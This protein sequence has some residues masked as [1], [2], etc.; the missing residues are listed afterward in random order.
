MLC[1]MCTV[2][3]RPLG[4]MIAGSEARSGES[5]LDWFGRYENSGRCVA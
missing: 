4:L 5:T 3:V 1:L 2:T